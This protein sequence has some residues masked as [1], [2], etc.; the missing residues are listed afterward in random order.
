MIVENQMIEIKCTNLINYYVQK[1][2]TYKKGVPLYVKAEDLSPGST[3]KIKVICDYCGIEYAMKNDYYQKNIVNGEIKKCA[4]KKCQ[5]FKTREHNLIKYGV[6]HTALLPEVREKYKRA[7]LAKYGVQ[8]ANQAEEV[9]QKKIK[10][11]LEVYGVE[12]VFQAKEIKEKIKSTNMK[13]YGTENPFSNE[14]IKKK[15]SKAIEYVNGR[16]ISKEQKRIAEIFNGVLNYQIDNYNVDILLE[17]NI[18]IECDGK[19]HDLHV[20]LGRVSQEEFDKKEKKRTKYLLDTG[21]KIIR[22]IHKR[23]T[24]IFNDEYLS[25]VQE[26][27]KYLKYDSIVIYDFDN[28]Q[29][30]MNSSY[31]A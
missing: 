20:V 8:N 17:N 15:H 9:K 27:I 14:D 22:L 21:Y 12:N 30:L 19:G 13:K 26:C 1:G 4:C 6:E 3:R 29:F 2:Y 5:Y 7:C 10:K 31:Y 16:K 18:I 24:N 23:N 11:A 28:K 25:I